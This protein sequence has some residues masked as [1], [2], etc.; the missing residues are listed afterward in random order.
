MEYKNIF[1]GGTHARVQF[2]W[3]TQKKA[4]DLSQKD[5][6]TFRHFQL[7]R[8]GFKTLEEGQKVSFYV[9]QGNRET[10]QLTL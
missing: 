9:T 10:K 6:M 4:L 8:D 2:K 1:L 3:L 7:F 5:E